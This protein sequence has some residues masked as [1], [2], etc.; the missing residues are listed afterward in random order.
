MTE[1]ILVKT[2]LQGNILENR[3]ERRI[4]SEVKLHL[5]VYHN[6]ADAGAVVHAHPPAATAFACAEG[7]DAPGGL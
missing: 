4:S 3:D 6:R 2:D 1:D 7:V 5:R